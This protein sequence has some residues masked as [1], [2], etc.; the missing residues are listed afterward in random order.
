MNF[1]PEPR[2]KVI[3]TQ[4]ARKAERT[5]R[6]DNRQHK[7]EEVAQIA[8]AME[9]LTNEPE[10]PLDDLL[11]DDE[12]AKIYAEAKAKVAAERKA[13]RR[14]II[15]D[16]ALEDERREAGMIPPETEHEEWL[17]QE[18][19]ISI[20]LPALRQPNGREV[21]RDP[22]LI[23]G[24]SF[25]HGRTYTV[26]LVQALYLSDIM[27]RLRQHVSQV[28]GR[29]KNYYNEQTGQ[30]V[31]MGGTARGGTPGLAFDSI[32]KRPQ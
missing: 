8:A 25:H 29:H 16:K 15:M 4:L 11:S 9:L 21:T 12:I 30:M 31:Y 26:P 32:H 10:A 13:A 24:K 7:V 22:I 3:A 5:R 14:K 19:Q 18:A 27:S 17:Q 23:D 28:D 2:A 1:T 6:T 20:V